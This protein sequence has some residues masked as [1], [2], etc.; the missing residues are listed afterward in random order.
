MDLVTK[1]GCLPEHRCKSI[2][3]QIVNAIDYCHRN[4][5]IHRDMKLENVIKAN[6]DPDCN[7]IKIVDFG[8][9][10]LACGNQSEVT[11]AGSL[12]Y[13]PPEIFN[14]RNVRAGPFLD[15]W[16]IGC[17][18][19]AM[20][21]GSL[22]FNGNDVSA[23]KHSIRYDPVLFPMDCIVTPDCK[24]IIRKMLTKKSD[25]RIVM[26]E[27]KAHPWLK[28]EG[29]TEE[30]GDAY[31]DQIE[32]EKTPEQ[33]AKENKQ[34]LA[35][36][37]KIRQKEERKERKRHLKV[38]FDV[39]EEDNTKIKKKKV[40]EKDQHPS[41][42]RK[43]ESHPNSKKAAE[44]SPSKKPDETNPLKKPDEPNA[45]KKID[46]SIP[47]KT[48]EK[49]D[50]F[51]SPAQKTTLEIIDEATPKFNKNAKPFNKTDNNP[52]AKVDE[53]Y[54]DD[55]SRDGSCR[56][57]SFK[58]K[59]KADLPK[60]ATDK[61]FYRPKKKAKKT[62]GSE[63]YPRKQMTETPKDPFYSLSKTKKKDKIYGTDDPFDIL[64]HTKRSDG[65][66]IELNRE[67]ASS[68]ERIPNIDVSP[69][70]GRKAR[71]GTEPSKNRR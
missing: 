38:H 2:L 53:I 19:Y 52:F 15:I 25:D 47:L 32:N 11:N 22:P 51:K 36:E 24:D 37:R 60:E 13:L 17:M 69:S 18:L 56:S 20:I 21:V 66:Y 14:H 10:G 5:I 31:L 50:I 54:G 26:L 61:K 57:T 40:F 43:E 65:K 8:I 44:T 12:N 39:D 16:A 1:K 49:V 71:I 62:T 68:N 70:P 3:K 67:V 6:A 30:V 4:K 29:G 45:T 7:L 33:K 9:A 23:L 48:I 59:I 35:D 42:K 55:K 27:L 46:N 64:N 63:F 28:A 58:Y 41:F 34:S